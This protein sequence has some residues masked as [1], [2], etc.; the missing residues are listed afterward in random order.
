MGVYEE[1]MASRARPGPL[2][3]LPFHTGHADK[4]GFLLL[5]STDFYTGPFYDNRIAT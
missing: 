1:F 3:M 4:G 2:A 5:V